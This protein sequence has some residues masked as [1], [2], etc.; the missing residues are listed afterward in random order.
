MSDSPPILS[1]SIRFV[2]S[3]SGTDKVFRTIVYTTRVLAYFFAKK[4]GPDN[5]ISKRL[6]NLSSPLAETRIIFRLVGSLSAID[7]VLVNSEQDPFLRPIRAI[8]NWSMMIY[9]PFENIYWLGAH[10]IVPMS[11]D[12][13]T[14]LSLWS[15]R[16]W[17]VYIVLDFIADCYTIRLLLEQE[18][19][20]KKNRPV[21]KRTQRSELDQEA[22][23]GSGFEIFD[24]YF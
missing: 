20:L 4:Y 19:E 18:K 23:K 9:Y 22:E 3:V 8:Q 11:A 15:C 16:A 5:T 13:Q 6:T 24:E 2:S 12:A 17:L 10:E 1:K 7:G 14:Q 21:G